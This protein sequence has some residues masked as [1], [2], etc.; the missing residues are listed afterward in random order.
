MFKGNYQ[1]QPITAPVATGID[2]VGAVESDNAPVY[3]VSGQRVGA[4]YKG[5]VIKNGKK[6][7]RK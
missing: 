7:I 1:V 4:A 6:F 3:N 5:L 2:A